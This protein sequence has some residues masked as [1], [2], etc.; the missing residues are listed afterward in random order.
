MTV[1]TPIRLE[2]TDCHGCGKRVATTAPLCRHCN[3]RRTPT[4]IPIVANI[5]RSSSKDYRDA[6]SG[7][8]ADDENAKDADSH[9]ALSMGGYDLE[10]IDDELESTDATKK[11]D[12]W[13]FVA[14]GLLIVFSIG[15][16]VPWF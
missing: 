2:F 5:T 7:N 4:P 9:A 13:W 8:Q 10:G 1:P 16:L 14:L 15:A 12:L 3:T 11:K 6:K